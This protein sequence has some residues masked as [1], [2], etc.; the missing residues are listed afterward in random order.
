M[1]TFSTIVLSCLCF[2][3]LFF[4]NAAQNWGVYYI[5]A[6]IYTK[7]ITVYLSLKVSLTWSPL[8]AANFLI[9]VSHRVMEGVAVGVGLVVAVAHG[10]T[11]SCPTQQL[12]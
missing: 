6:C 12:L 2:L 3:L 10:S 11:W 9:L 8:L 7:V 1:S 4:Q 5:W